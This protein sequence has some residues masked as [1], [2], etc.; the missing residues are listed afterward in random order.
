MQKAAAQCQQWFQTWQAGIGRTKLG[1]NR[2]PSSLHAMTLFFFLKFSK[3][4]LSP[5]IFEQIFQKKILHNLQWNFL[6]WKWLSPPSSFASLLDIFELNIP[7]GNQIFCKDFF[8]CL[9]KALKMID[10]TL[11]ICSHSRSGYLR[12]NPVQTGFY[13]CIDSRRLEATGVWSKGDD[14]PNHPP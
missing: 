9:P 10:T 8:R 11:F 5:L 4:S 3:W 1:S 7:F 14:A 12:A 2:E 6:D 13:F